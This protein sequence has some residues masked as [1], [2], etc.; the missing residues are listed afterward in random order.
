MKTIRRSLLI[1]LVILGL[2]PWPAV[3]DRLDVFETGK[4]FPV[5]FLFKEDIPSLKNLS[6]DEIE[7]V[8]QKFLDARDQVESPVQNNLIQLGISYIYLLQKNY[9]KSLEIL[10]QEFNGDFILEDFRTYFLTVVLRALAEE[11]VQEEDFSQAIQYLNEA[12]KYQMILYKNFPSSP[13]H[14]DVSPIL[15]QIET[16]L[17][18]VYFKNGDYPAAWNSYNNALARKNSNCRC[19]GTH[20]KIYTALA[21]TQL[22]LIHI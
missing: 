10:N 6:P 17:G 9:I 7:P 20:L 2:T 1:L 3:A 19:D 15:A 21:Q 22:S 14:E 13:F 12:F 8:L 18:D 16:R 4:T 5:N 11:S